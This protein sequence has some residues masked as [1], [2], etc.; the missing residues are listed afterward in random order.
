MGAAYFKRRRENRW[1]ADVPDC[2]VSTATLDEYPAT[3]QFHNL[4]IKETCPGTPGGRRGLAIRYFMIFPS[5]KYL[6]TPESHPQTPCTPQSAELQVG[7]C[8]FVSPQSFFSPETY[9][10]LSREPRH[11]EHIPIQVLIARNGGFRA[12]VGF[13]AEHELTFCSCSSFSHDSPPLI[14]SIYGQ[15]MR[16]IA[17]QRGVS[18]S[19]TL[20]SLLFHHVMIHRLCDQKSQSNLSDSNLN[21][22][23][24]TSSTSRP[25]LFCLSVAS[26]S[27]SQF[28]LP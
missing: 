18:A 9:S 25:P 11:P 19:C 15:R 10:H 16:R 8:R 20:C 6:V 1:C 26:Y 7:V 27:S 4:D 13:F 5:L 22:N 28:L 17:Y 3:C 14:F 12:R 24:Q 21:A 2:P 23:S